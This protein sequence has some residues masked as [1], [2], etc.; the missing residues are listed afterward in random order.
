VHGIENWRI[1]DGSG[2]TRGAMAMVRG[3]EGEISGWCRSAVRGSAVGKVAAYSTAMPRGQSLGLLLMA[4]RHEQW[5][6]W[7]LTLGLRSAWGWVG[8]ASQRLDRST[9]EGAEQPLVL[10]GGRDGHMGKGAAGV[11]EIVGLVMPQEDTSNVVVSSGPQ[12]PCG[13]RRRVA[14]DEA[15]IHRWEARPILRPEVR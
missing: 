6:R 15:K 2:G 4:N 11:E 3:R 12:G 14:R 10:R 8:Y 13:T 1:W 9:K 7:D 5:E